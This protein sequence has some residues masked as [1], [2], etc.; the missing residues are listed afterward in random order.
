MCC[1]STLSLSSV[2]YCAICPPLTLATMGFEVTRQRTGARVF[3]RASFF[4]KADNGPVSRKKLACPYLGSS[5]RQRRGAAC[6]LGHTL[7]GITS[8][9]AGRRSRAHSYMGND[10][11]RWYDHRTTASLRRLASHR[12]YLSG[13]RD[14]MLSTS[15]RTIVRRQVRAAADHGNRYLQRAVGRHVTRQGHAT[16]RRRDGFPRA[17][18][19]SITN[20][21]P[22]WTIPVPLGHRACRQGHNDEWSDTQEHT[23]IDAGTSV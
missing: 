6:V 22:A 4:D 10:G 15:G 7:V 23:V 9:I 21:R 12:A 3:R 16:R 20:A 11:M 8:S 2:A 1:P 17:R 19:T 13:D 14:R 18:W 5:G